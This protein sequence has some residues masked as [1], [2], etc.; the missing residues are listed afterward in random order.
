MKIE[1]DGV[2]PKNYTRINGKAEKHDTPEVF[3]VLILL[4]SVS[5]KSN[6]YICKYISTLPEKQGELKFKDVGEREVC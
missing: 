1:E 4:Y 6:L 2:N 5:H 3:N